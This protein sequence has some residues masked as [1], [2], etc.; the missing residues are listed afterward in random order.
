MVH[1]PGSPGSVAKTMAT[2][3]MHFKT[4]FP[5]SSKR[6]W[7]LFT[8]KSRYPT[9]LS[10]EIITEILDNSN[11]SLANLTIQV[12]LLENPRAREAMVNAH[13]VYIQMIDIVETI[14]KKYA[15]GA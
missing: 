9:E 4:Q 7:L 8:L 3:Y 5:H 10:P 11:E 14:T 6:E 2:I 1:G 15:P 13:S 12:V